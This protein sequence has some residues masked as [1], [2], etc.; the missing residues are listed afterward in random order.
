MARESDEK[1]FMIRLEE[2]TPKEISTDGAPNGKL[3]QSLE[4][5]NFRLDCKFS[6]E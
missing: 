2:V 6:E 5:C 4:Y 1:K 3:R